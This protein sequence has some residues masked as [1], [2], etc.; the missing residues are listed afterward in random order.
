MRDSRRRHQRRA[1]HSSVNYLS[2]PLRLSSLCGFP[3]VFQAMTDLA[4]PP[5]SS[6]LS[7]DE[8]TPGV[9]YRGAIRDTF[10]FRSAD[11]PASRF[12]RG[13]S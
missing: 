13:S 1:T 6:N 9:P 5:N 3:D 10:A 12:R 11:P 2:P 7:R 8:T 4:Y